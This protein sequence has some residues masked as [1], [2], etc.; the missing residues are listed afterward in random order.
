MPGKINYTS[1]F[2]NKLGVERSEPD[3]YQLKAVE[4]WNPNIELIRTIINSNYERLVLNWDSDIVDNQVI[5]LGQYI[6]YLDE[7]YRCTTSY[8]VGTPKTFTPANFQKIG[9]AGQTPNVWYLN[10]SHTDGDGSQSNPFNDLQT[11]IDA[12]SNGDVINITVLSFGASDVTLDGKII[13][14]NGSDKAAVIFP[15]ISGTGSAVFNRTQFFSK[16]ISLTDV[17]FNDSVCISCS[18]SVSSRYSSFSSDIECTTPINCIAISIISSTFTNSVTSTGPAVTKNRISNSTIIGDV[19]ITDELVDWNNVIT[20]TT[21]VTPAKH[22]FERQASS[23]PTDVRTFT[24]S[25]PAIIANQVTLDFD[26]KNIGEFEISTT[27]TA[28]LEILLSNTTNAVRCII[29]GAI[30][31][32]FAIDLT[33]F[34]TTNCKPAGELWIYAAGLVTIEGV[35][36]TPF[37][38]SLEKYGSSWNVIPYVIAQ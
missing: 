12:A 5:A 35:T 28:A 3:Q 7:Q 11:A 24:A 25:S 18:I 27:V 21:T 1:G 10:S 26:S 9:G 13:I 19:T 37:E 15:G 30:T 2:T 4:E 36:S 16:T 33:E 17:F 20:G 38:I 6:D 29:K 31:G 23:A 32:T 22:D 34:G 8:D 14:F